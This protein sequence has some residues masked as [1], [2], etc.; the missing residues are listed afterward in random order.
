MDFV[1]FSNYGR[2]VDALL[3]GTVDIAWNTNLA[4]VRTV[5]Q[6]DGRV[7]ALAKRDTDLAFRSHLVCRTGAGLR[8]AGDLTG[9]RPGAGQPRQGN[10]GQSCRRHPHRPRRGLHRAGGRHAHHRRPAR[11]EGPAGLPRFARHRPRASGGPPPR[12]RGR[13]GRRPGTHRPNPDPRSHHHR[14]RRL[15]APGRSR[16]RRAARHPRHLPSRC[17]HRS[18]ASSAPTGTRRIPPPARSPAREPRSRAERR[19][20]WPGRLADP[21]TPAPHPPPI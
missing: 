4:W 14:R 9:R 1:L 18:R 16:Q 5:L 8:G 15:L 10:L 7:R 20:A 2:Q 3:A 6:A 11:G 13:R 12:T 21:D 19:H 17:R